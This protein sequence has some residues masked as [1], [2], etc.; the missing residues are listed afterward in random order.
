MAYQQGPPGQPPNYGP[1]PG[2]GYPP[3]PPPKKSNTPIILMV[4]GVA[5]VLLFGGCA[6]LVAVVG[7]NAPEVVT[8]T[9]PQASKPTQAA[10]APTSAP[11]AAAAAV[12]SAITLQGLDPGLQVE[13][14]VTKVVAPATPGNE[15]LKP[16]AGNRYVAVE[17]Q[18]ANKGQAVYDDS[19]S[20]GAILIDDQ[21]QQY[22]AGFGEV[23][24]G[25]ALTAATIASGDSRKGVIVYEIPEGVKLAKFQFGL[26]SGFASQKGEWTLGS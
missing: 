23:R 10:K 7:S 5:A 17:L 8:A 13:V 3:P 6:A 22:R 9:A 16:K 15:F 21:G 14:T 4:I 11:P 19:P 24:E 20:N 18:L 2:Y 25:V 12:G 1:P 26:N